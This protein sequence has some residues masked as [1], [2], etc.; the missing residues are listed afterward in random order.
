[1]TAPTRQ[2]LERFL[3]REIPISAAMTIQVTHLSDAAITL[4]SAL[5]ANHNDKGTAFGGSLASLMTLA[6]WAL[7]L[8]RLQQAQFDCDLLI[9]RQEIRYDQPAT[10]DFHAQ[11]ELP[12][13]QWQAFVERFEKRGKARIG[14]SIKTTTSHGT[15][16]SMEASYVAVVKEPT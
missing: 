14:L 15:V 6:G 7:L 13:E 3:H 8:C 12:Q 10:E 16:A 1:M 9:H 11:C 2:Q 4:S 5:A